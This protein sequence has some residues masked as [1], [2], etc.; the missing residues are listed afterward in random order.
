MTRSTDLTRTR[1][2]FTLIELLIVV[3]IIAI[4]AAIAI[5]N[6]LEAQTRAK[7][8]RVKADLR[9]LAIALEAYMTDANHYPWFSMAGMDPQYNQIAYRLCGLTTPIAYLSSVSYEDTF[10]AGGS[11]GNYTDN[12]PRTQYNYRNHEFVG[13]TGLPAGRK[14]WVL[15]SLGPDRVKNQGL[16]VELLARGI[17]SGQAATVI[18]DPTNGT[19]SAGDIP[20]TGGATR[21]INP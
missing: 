6:F 8:S 15:N 5:P 13:A 16:N 10:I 20:R 17:P 2:G 12:L 9:S 14:I 19:I 21:Y 3:A 7:V 11:M 1:R 18:Y 4:L